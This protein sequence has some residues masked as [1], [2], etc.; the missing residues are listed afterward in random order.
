[1]LNKKGQDVV[2]STLGKWIILIAG[3]MVV[4]LV[5]SL[6]FFR[7]EGVTKEQTCH[8][9]VISRISIPIGN[10]EFRL[11]PLSCET[12]D[13]KI[14]GNREEIKRQVADSM[15]RCWWMFN[16]GR[17]D[18]VLSSGE[19]KKALGFEDNKNQCFLC[20]T[21]TVDQDSI[22]GGEIPS[23][24][25]FNY[26]LENNHPKIAGT[27]YID[28]IQSYGG[29]GAVGVLSPIKAKDIYGVVYLSKS[30]DTSTW[31][32][33][34]V[35]AAAAVVGGGVACFTGIGCTV[36]GPLGAAGAA[37]LGSHGADAAQALIYS[38]QRAVSSIFIDNL[39]SIQQAG[40]EVKDFS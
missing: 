40:C 32:W 16:E 8:A 22:V 17:Q 2:L 7:A 18:E 37:Y 33:A 3:F 1:M 26:L 29:P 27:T 35:G 23:E 12:I 15:E 31:T 19:V 24:E 10:E 20:Y 38:E 36:G 4:V 25:T 6:L 28:Y 5:I 39:N 11:G 21:L 34:D 14:S 9:S 30:K 13:E